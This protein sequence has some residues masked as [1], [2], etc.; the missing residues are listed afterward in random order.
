MGIRKKQRHGEKGKDVSRYGEVRGEQ[1]CSED[2]NRETERC[3]GEMGLQ[4]P[5]RGKG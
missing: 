1:T 4:K 5:A 2:E 3:G